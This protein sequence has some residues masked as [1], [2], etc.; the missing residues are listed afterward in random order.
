MYIDAVPD[1]VIWTVNWLYY[2]NCEDIT[3]SSSTCYYSLH[4]TS[5]GQ[6]V[7]SYGWCNGFPCVVP[8][9]S[10]FSERIRV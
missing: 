8:V 7:S 10:L 3:C 4:G 2:L 9:S 6:T 1:V 5:L